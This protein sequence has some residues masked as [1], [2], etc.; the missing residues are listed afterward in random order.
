MTNDEIITLL[1]T[2]LFDLDTK[3]YDN[4]KNTL[5]SLLQLLKCKSELN[6][7]KHIVYAKM[8][9]YNTRDKSK[10]KALYDFYQKLKN[11][12]KDSFDFATYYMKYVNIIK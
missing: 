11:L 5:E 3:A 8:Q 6:V 10:N 12:S 4:A 1:E 2:I 7:F 9:F